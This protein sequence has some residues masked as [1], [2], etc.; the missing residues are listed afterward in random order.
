M[1]KLIF[2]ILAVI[3]LG[4]QAYGQDIFGPP[5]Y[6]FKRNDSVFVRPG[7]VFGSTPPSTFDSA[8]YV[9]RS[10]FS[11]SITATGGAFSINATLGQ[12]TLTSS[13]DMSLITD[14]LMSLMSNGGGGIA[15]TT[16]GYFSFTDADGNSYL[17]RGFGT[18]S[19]S[20]VT[21]ATMKTRTV[22]L[23]DGTTAEFYCPDE[24]LLKK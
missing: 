2:V 12:I 1:K 17:V 11:Q 6:F 23:M 16:A 19:G 21:P 20:G 4:S 13:D 7:T 8:L 10:A 3:G 14:G 5:N 15:L 22:I 9:K 18:P 24:K